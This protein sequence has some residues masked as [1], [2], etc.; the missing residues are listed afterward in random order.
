MFFFVFVAGQEISKH[1][2]IRFTLMQGGKTEPCLHVEHVRATLVWKSVRFW[3]LRN[4]VVHKLHTEQ[5][6]EIHKLAP[7]TIWDTMRA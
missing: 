7:R 5:Q 1:Q 3:L 6:Y 4:P 2:N